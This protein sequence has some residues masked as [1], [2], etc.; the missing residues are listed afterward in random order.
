[1]SDPVG[2]PRKHQ[3]R[4]EIPR[5][6]DSIPE[7]PKLQNFD[8]PAAFGA[9]VIRYWNRVRNRQ[10]N[11]QR[12]ASTREAKERGEPVHRGKPA[13][14]GQPKFTRGR[15]SRGHD[16]PKR[17]RTPKH[18]L[19]DPR[20]KWENRKVTRSPVRY[21]SR[22]QSHQTFG[23]EWDADL[24]RERQ[25]Q[26]KSTM[27]GKP[28]KQSQPTSGKPKE[29]LILPKG[30]RPEAVHLRT[31]IRALPGMIKE[32]EQFVDGANAVIKLQGP[33]R[34]WTDWFEDESKLQAALDQAANALGANETSPTK[35]VAKESVTKKS[36]A[37]DP[38]PK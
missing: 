15:E 32:S 36:V 9:E 14:R 12:R 16:K 5:N 21:Q 28:G 35:S 7:F 22:S 29:E 31:R 6:L 19:P 33:I 24:N 18:L 10:R 11:W 1:M 2:V 3:P 8:R 25:R 20:G 13:Y 34:F 27:P 37:K 38:Y 23:F 17:Y 30:S 4:L 26:S